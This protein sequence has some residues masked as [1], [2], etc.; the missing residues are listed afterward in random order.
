[1]A[2]APGDVVVFP[3][4]VPG[5][6][7]AQGPARAEGGRAA[8]PVTPG[9]YP[10]LNGTDTVGALVVAPDPRESDLTRAADRDVA[11]VFPGAL[12]R[13]VDSPRAYAAARF[14]GSGQGELTPWLLVA[15][16]VVLVAE[17][18]VAAGVGRRAG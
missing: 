5:F 16:L 2:A 1:V 3:D 7:A 18:L 11:A 6:A 14:S 13:V 10:L 15:A 9:V 17:S 12:V 8:A 4:G